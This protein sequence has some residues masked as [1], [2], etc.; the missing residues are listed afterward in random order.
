M[1]TEQVDVKKEENVQEMLVEN[2]AITAQMDATQTTQPERDESVET[3]V[4]CVT[5]EGNEQLDVNKEENAQ[6]MLVENPAVTQVVEEMDSAQ[7]QVEQATLPERDGS[8]ETEVVCMTAGEIEQVDVQKKENA[9]E[10]L[11]ENPAVTHDAAQVDS[12]HRQ[13]PTTQR[14]LDGSVET[15]VACV[16]TEE[17][18][19]VD[20]NKEENA[21]EMLVEN[22][23]VT[24]D[25]VQM[26]SIQ[27]QGQQ[28]TQPE[29][30]GSVETEVACVT[31][32][33]IEPME[34]NQDNI[35]NVVDE[36]IVAVTDST[37]LSE[38]EGNVECVETVP[39]LMET[40][41]LTVKEDSVTQEVTQVTSAQSDDKIS[42]SDVTEGEVNDKGVG[43]ELSDTAANRAS[44][45]PSD[46]TM[47]PVPVAMEIDIHGENNDAS[48]LTKYE[49]TESKLESATAQN[50]EPS[51]PPNSKEVEASSIMKVGTAA[52]HDASE[53][54]VQVGNSSAE[55]GLSTKP[56]SNT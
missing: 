2:P 5:A 56:A 7:R 54:L 34:T 13:E 53:A 27:A 17:N 46:T 47:P 1:I 4:L 6:E 30:D 15:E 39:E 14:E 32:K 49:P 38:H 22:P 16:T 29:R 41:Q 35:E 45:V 19:R 24:Q 37:S 11:V 3:E 12:T 50:S 9:Q 40:D 48:S 28:T 52:E 42:R 36:L 55:E 20:V 8:V 44:L 31:A 25:G 33:E 43:S 21:Q 23:A 26:D 18:E 10:M 51:Q